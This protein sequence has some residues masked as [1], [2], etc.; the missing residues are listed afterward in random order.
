M[1]ITNIGHATLLMELGGV[2]IL[3]DP[4]FDARLGGLLSRVTRPGLS[5]DA[6][7]RPDALL[8]T[9]AHADHLSL[10]SL[11][12]VASGGPVPLYAPPGVAHWLR[13]RGYSAARSLAPGGAAVITGARGSVT[14]W[15]GAAAHQGSRYG[16]DRWAGRAAANTYLVDSGAESIFFAG[17]TGLTADSHALVADRLGACGRR[18]DVALLPIGYAPWWKP[19]FRRGHLSA[20]D[21]L[22]L[23]GR[24]DARALI[25]YHWGTFHHLTS[26]PFD[27]MRQL[28]TQL[29][30]YARRPDVKIVPPGSTISY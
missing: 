12:I 10:A 19:R 13:S 24:L 9:H 25:P 20:A 27:A 1:R 7:P 15:A 30:G 4:N 3:T 6:L 22:T 28:E 21:A 5:W 23:F 16:V 26:G 18:L 29:A 2:R 11:D 8:L 17:D 14:V